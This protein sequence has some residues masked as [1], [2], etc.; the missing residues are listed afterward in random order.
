MRYL[1]VF[2][3]AVIALLAFA[4]FAWAADEY[5]VTPELAKK[6]AL[7][8]FNDLLPT[9][10][11][12][13]I[14]APA[15][16][17]PKA[18]YSYDLTRKYYALYVYCGPGNIP[19]WG[20]LAGNIGYYRKLYKYFHS[21]IIPVDKRDYVDRGG[22]NGIPPFLR[23]EV[24][25]RKSLELNYKPSTITYVR[26]IISGVNI[27]LLFKIGMREVVTSPSGGVLQPDEYESNPP[28]LE[29]PLLF[30]ESISSNA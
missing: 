2:L 18:V 8:F 4:G 25:A 15:V 9:L 24:D 23:G 10:H 17:E 11:K 27:Y 22:F 30:W 6:A 14:S 29:N 12:E 3:A 1:K 19:S 5:E 21:Y 13:I 20:V 16:S 7:T 26:P 28:L